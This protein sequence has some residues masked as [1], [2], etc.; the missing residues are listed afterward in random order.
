MYG[1]DGSASAEEWVKQGHPP[2]SLTPQDQ[3]NLL[4][5]GKIVWERGNLVVKKNNGK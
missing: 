2:S 4:R 1:F 3:A 5:A